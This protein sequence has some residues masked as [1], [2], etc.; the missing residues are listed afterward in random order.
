MNFRPSMKTITLASLS[1]LVTFLFQIPVTDAASTTPYSLKQSIMF[2]LNPPILSLL[3]TFYIISWGVKEI[4]YRLAARNAGCSTPVRYWHKEPILGFD[5]FLQ[6]IND[7]K[8]GDSVATDRNLLHKY[9][10]T[11][12]T[13]SWG[14]KQ[15]VTMDPLNMQTILATQVEKFGS[16]PMNLPMCKPF[17]GQGLLTTDG[18]LW[19]KSRQMINPVFA[20][21]QV[22]ELSTFEKHLDRMISCIPTDGSTI[23]MQPLCKLLFLDSSTEFIFGKSANSLS[24]ET[25]S[26]I[27]RRLPGLFDE[28]LNGMFMRYMLGRFKFLAISDKKWLATCAEVHNIIDSF[29]DEEIALQSKS[30]TGDTKSAGPYSYVLLKELVKTTKD[31]R[32]IRNEVMNVFFPAR[33]TAAI[34]ISNVLFMLARHPKVWDKLREEVLGIGEEKLTF[35]SLKSLKYMH[36]VMN[37]SKSY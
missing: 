1:S 37:E 10:K 11:V 31:K 12:L 4:L 32:S 2:I 23:D 17:L 7:M 18:A 25:D 21:A 29:I 35:E 5:L 8:L 20:R 26:P 13:N 24:P 6:R 14:V 15:Y 3:V 33:D 27:A 30:K 28:A 16:A 19:K 34:H 9:G 36:A 22:S